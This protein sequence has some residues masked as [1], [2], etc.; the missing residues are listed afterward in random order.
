[1]FLVPVPS[2]KHEWLVFFNVRHDRIE[3]EG[4]DRDTVHLHEIHRFVVTGGLHLSHGTFKLSVWS[5]DPQKVGLLLF[6]NVEIH[7]RIDVHS[8]GNHL[9]EASI[10]SVGFFELV[11]G[12]LDGFQSG[13]I[14]VQGS[15]EYEEEIG[16]DAFLNVVVTGRECQPRIK[17]RRQCG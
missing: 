16:L 4:F 14:I 17:G 12:S 9:V 10:E 2:K 1:M 8:E 6:G 13:G 15:G 11:L 3:P 7:G 5:I